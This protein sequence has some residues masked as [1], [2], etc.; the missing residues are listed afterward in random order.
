MSSPGAFPPFPL[1]QLNAG[2]PLIPCPPDL[3]L[4]LSLPLPG[5]LPLTTAGAAAAGVDGA[6]G[7]V[8]RFSL[9]WAVRRAVVALGAATLLFS[10]LS[11]RDYEREGY[12]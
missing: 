12:R 3:Q 7:A 9:K 10:L 2:A 4:L 5:W 8:L 11:Y 1:L 6:V